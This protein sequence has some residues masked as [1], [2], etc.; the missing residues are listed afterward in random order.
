MIVPADWYDEPRQV[1]GGMPTVRFFDQLGRR[2]AFDMSVTIAWSVGKEPSF[3]DPAR[4]RAFVSQSAEEV[5]AVASERRV[6][7]RGL[8]GA[9]GVGYYFQATLK[10]QPA[11]QP[12][13]LTQGALVVD[14]LLLT[15]S[16]FTADPRAAFVE[17]ALTMLKG[18]RHVP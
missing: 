17:Q 12:P 9:S 11:G 13:H 10:E 3:T 5:A 7:V 4:L 2:P 8:E 16:I 6:T 18:A 15:F 1:S 14:K